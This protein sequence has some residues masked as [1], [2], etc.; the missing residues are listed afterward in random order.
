MLLTTQHGASELLDSAGKLLPVLALLSWET[1]AWDPSAATSSVEAAR[2]T[3]VTP[4]GTASLVNCAGAVRESS[5]K[6]PDDARAWTDFS[7][8]ISREFHA[9]ETVL[10]P[11]ASEKIFQVPSWDGLGSGRRTGRIVIAIPSALPTKST[12]RV[13][14]KP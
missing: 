4:V 14:K 2:V 1:A 12:H 11:G 13:H 9:S 10:A 6:A 5:D 7:L 3:A 8:C